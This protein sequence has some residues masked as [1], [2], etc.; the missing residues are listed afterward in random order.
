VGPIF[1]FPYQL[2]SI[3]FQTYLGLVII[4]IVLIYYYRKEFPTEPAAE[5][6]EKLVQG[7]FSEEGDTTSETE[8]QENV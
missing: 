2:V 7:P 6:S 5:I 1:S 3:G 4:A 8:A